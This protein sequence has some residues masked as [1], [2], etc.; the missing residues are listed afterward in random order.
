MQTANNDGL[1]Q[2]LLR[3]DIYLTKLDPVEGVERGKSRPAVIVQNNLGN[4]YGA[5][6]IIVPISSQ[7]EIK[8]TLP[9]MVPL[10]GGMGGLTLDSYADCGQI[11]TIDKQLR[12]IKK[13]GHLDALIMLQIDK[14]LKISLG[15]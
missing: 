8:K 12:L 7:K 4:Q 5:L 6:T 15:L 11:R 3:G 10:K 2:P 14:A 9:I 13:L 1:I